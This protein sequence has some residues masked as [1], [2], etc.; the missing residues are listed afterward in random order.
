MADKKITELNNIT[1]ADLAGTDEFVVVDISADE[2]KAMKFSELKIA[3]G[4]DHYTKTQSDARYLKLAGGTMSGNLKI[5]NANP[6]IDLVDTNNNPDWAIL[7][8]DGK[9]TVYN[10]TN[11]ILNLQLTTTGAEISGVLEVDGLYTWSLGTSNLRVGK[12]AGKVLA[13]GSIGN[14]MSGDD[15]GKSST[16]PDYNSFYGFQSGYS[17]ID[18]N[19]NTFIGRK[20]GYFITTGSKN[21]ILGGFNGNQS[22]L[23][24]RTS[25]NHI[26]LSDGDGNPR[27]HINSLGNVGVG[28]ANPDRTIKIHKNNAYFWIAD[29]A[30]GDVGFIGGNGDNDGYIRLYEGTG[31][32]SKVEIHSD[33]DSYFNGGNV[34]INEANPS[35]KLHVSGNVKATK[36]IGDGS[37]LTNL[38]NTGF[39]EVGT[40]T[41]AMYKN[42]P[43]GRSVSGGGTV[44]G[45]ELDAHT[46]GNHAQPLVQ[47]EFNA[48]KINENAGFAGTWRLMVYKVQ[49][50]NTAGTNQW[51]GGF[52]LRIA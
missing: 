34:G 12:D 7:N 25:N 29:A 42:D 24:I 10:E 41:V 11:N 26:V 39:G 19:R 36:F 27:L 5:E 15:A 20:A 22:G 6:R 49:L 13:S 23:D 30:G 43:A 47:Y 48:S 18:G 50:W 40:Y 45:S 37:E 14:T 51:V 4:D 38:V 21:V 46:D 35:E 1:G 33:A 17:N 2:T 8:N 52:W 44:A 16:T 32:T 9:F 3:V 28:T 31:H